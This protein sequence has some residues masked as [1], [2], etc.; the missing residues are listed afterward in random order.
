[1]AWFEFEQWL[2]KLTSFK[3]VPSLAFVPLAS[4]L[5]SIQPK[6]KKRKQIKE[7]K[8]RTKFSLE[9]IAENSVAEMA[10]TLCWSEKNTTIHARRVIDRKRARN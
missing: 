10:K 5:K 6:K 7:E 3:T 2:A 4:P 9:K 8:K 1:M